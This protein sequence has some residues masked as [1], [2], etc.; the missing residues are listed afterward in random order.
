[1][2]FERPFEEN[3]GSHIAEPSSWDWPGVLCDDG[4]PLPLRP[5]D[6]VLAQSSHSI[7]FD[8]PLSVTLSIDSARFARPLEP[9]NI[10]AEHARTARTARS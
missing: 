2:L 7:C 4:N 5:H 10:T 9:P 6:G 3:S 1:M 8:S